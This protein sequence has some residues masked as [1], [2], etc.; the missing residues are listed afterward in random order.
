[1]I[2]QGPYSFTSDLIGCI[3]WPVMLLGFAGC[4]A[5]AVAFLLGCLAGALV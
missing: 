5:A 2:N 1:M 4:C 3:M